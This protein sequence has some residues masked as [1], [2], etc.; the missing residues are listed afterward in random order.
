VKWPLE[1]AIEF[2]QIVVTSNPFCAPSDYSELEQIICVEPMLSRRPD[3]GGT[4]GKERRE[5]L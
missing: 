3:F 2:F 4:S 1:T 5:M